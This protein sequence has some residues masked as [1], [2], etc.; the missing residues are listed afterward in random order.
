M[1]VATAAE[2]S[3]FASLWIGDRLPA[4][5]D[6]SP[7]T[8]TLETFTLLGALAIRTTRLQLGAW[9]SDVSRWNPGL[10]AKVVTTLDIISG[11]RAMLGFATTEDAEELEA[12]DETVG[13]C[14]A[15]LAEDDVSAHGSRVVFTHARNLPRPVQ[16]GGPRILVGITGNRSAALAARSADA[17]V[18]TGDHALATETV[19]RVRYAFEAVGRDPTG[20]ATVWWGPLPST[21]G[22]PRRQA[23][24]ALEGGADE[25]VFT[26]RAPFRVRPG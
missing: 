5:T 17:V 12:L 3:G 21:G 10:L 25:V 19:A 8:H 20:I 15:L 14:R 2:R 26:V 22:D 1:R 24:P 13:L 11:G 4:G 9:I 6:T 16:P 18:V 7:D 23:A